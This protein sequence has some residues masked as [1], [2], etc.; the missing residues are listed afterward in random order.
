VVCPR[1]WIGVEEREK[2]PLITPPP[3]EWIVLLTDHVISN[4]ELQN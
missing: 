2:K 4:W 3:L 1:D